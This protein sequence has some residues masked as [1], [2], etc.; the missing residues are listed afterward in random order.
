MDFLSLYVSSFAYSSPYHGG[1]LCTS[2]CDGYVSSLW[3]LSA[4]TSVVL[5][6]STR[7]GFSLLVCK[8]I[9][10]RTLTTTDAMPCTISASYVYALDPPQG[11][12]HLPLGCTLSI[13]V[14]TNNDGYAHNA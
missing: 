6:Y 5:M 4:F 9:L 12:T 3:L 13:L 14:D 8:A 2:Y 11:P 1:S 10:P 7:S